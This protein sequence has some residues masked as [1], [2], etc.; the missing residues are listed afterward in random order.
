M[1]KLMPTDYFKPY[2]VNEIVAEGQ[3]S[4][5][6]YIDETKV[7]R[8]SLTPIDGFRMLLE[9]T[10]EEREKYNL[11]KIYYF[12]ENYDFCIME[13]LYN[14]EDNFFS[15]VLRYR[16]DNFNKFYL[17]P[18]DEDI[19]IRKLLNKL[20]DLKEVMNSWGVV[21]TL[22][23]STKNIMCRLDGVPVLASPIGEVYP[24]R[25]VS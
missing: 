3:F 11:P 21:F 4:R 8:V 20:L 23:V 25:W 10:D 19:R 13:R 6:Y 14:I 15:N 17:I 7:M 1:S 22:D 9:L 2:L 24:L 12:D 5:I 16:H 18:N